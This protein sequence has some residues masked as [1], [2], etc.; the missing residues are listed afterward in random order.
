MKEKILSILKDI[1][2]M[3]AKNPEECALPENAYYL[4]DKDVL[5]L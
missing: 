2:N 3:K 4:N 1:E 5:C